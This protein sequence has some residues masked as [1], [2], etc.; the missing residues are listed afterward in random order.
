MATLQTGKG[1]AAYNL[2]DA[3]TGGG[4]L[5]VAN[6]EGADV[7]ITRAV[8]HVETVSDAACDV[9]MGVAADGT[10]SD[11]TLI[12]QLDVGA[13]TGAFDYIDEQ[14]SNGESCVVWPSDE[15]VTIS[16]ASGAAEG[17]EGTAYVE[18]VRT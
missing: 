10:T 6:P 18:Y 5:S 11:D 9:D 17:L 16:K 12:D 1:A 13:A 8:V 15:Y 7:I 2:S 3:D 14:G 4:V